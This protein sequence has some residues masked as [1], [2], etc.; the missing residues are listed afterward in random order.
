MNML[1]GV[2]REVRRSADSGAAARSGSAFSRC[3]RRARPM[4]PR[5]P[6]SRRFIRSSW[7][8]PAAPVGA[9]PAHPDR[10]MESGTLPLPGGVGAHPA[11]PPCRSR[12]ADRDGCRRAA[13]R[14]GTHDRPRRRATR[15]A[16]TA[17][18]WSSSNWCR[19]RRRLASRATATTTPKATMATA[20]SRRCRCEAPARDPPGRDGG[21]VHR[22]DRPPAP[23]RQPHGDRRHIQ[24]RRHPL[25]RLLGASGEPHR[26]R[27]PRAADADTAR[28]A[29]CLCRCRC[30]W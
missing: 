15:A 27:R 26:R 24:R 9:A 18:G 8:Q 2:W 10:R 7:R 20:S 12:A 25:R 28:C 21:L 14:A 29:R 11:T 5:L 3:R 30:P 23:H 1:V 17:M 16:A 6:R 22:P 19:W 13:H 4:P